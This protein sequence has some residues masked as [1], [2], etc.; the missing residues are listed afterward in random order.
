MF[1]LK[2]NVKTVFCN[3]HDVSPTLRHFKCYISYKTRSTKVF[4]SVFIKKRYSTAAERYIYSV[5]LIS[6]DTVSFRSAAIRCSTLT[7]IW[8]ITKGCNKF[9]QNFNFILLD[10]SNPNG[11]IIFDVLIYLF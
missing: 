3:I 6:F 8:K 10:F 4:K 9:T 1:I 5:F 7:R 2:Q 11:T